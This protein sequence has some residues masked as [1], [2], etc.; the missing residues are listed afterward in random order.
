M[1]TILLVST[2]VPHYRVSVYNYFWR[3]F[4]ER[5][6]DFRVASSGLQRENRLRVNFEHDE[7]PFSFGRYK[8]FINRIKPDVII[9]HLRP[10][11]VIY[12]Y[13]IHWLKLKRIP[14]ISWTKGGNLEK[15]NSRVHRLL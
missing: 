8:R 5:G 4:R 11:D 2:W 7:I 1:K 6:W 15:P 9:F 13:L 10:K 14:F 3:R 12:W